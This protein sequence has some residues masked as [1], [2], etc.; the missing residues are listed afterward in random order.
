MIGVENDEQ[1]QPPSDF[2]L[3]NTF[4][5]QWEK[6]INE[7]VKEE[8]VTIEQARIIIAESISHY[9]DTD[10]GEKTLLVVASGTGTGKTTTS[11]ASLNR[12]GRRAIF[13]MP[14]KRH[15]TIL[16]ENYNFIP[17]YWHQWIGLSDGSLVDPE[18]TMCREFLTA[19]PILSARL[20]LAAA[21]AICPI[22]RGDCEYHLQKKSRKLFIAT[23]HNYL[24]SPFGLDGEEPKL[25]FVDEDPTSVFLD[26]IYV[27]ARDFVFIGDPRVVAFMKELMTCCH[28]GKHLSGRDLMDR[29]R[30]YADGWVEAVTEGHLPRTKAPSN[31]TEACSLKRDAWEEFNDVFMRELDAYDA[32]PERYADR[33]VCGETREKVPSMVIKYRSYISPQIENCKFIILDGTADLNHYRNLFPD[34]KIIFVK[35]NVKQKGKLFQIV[36]NQLGITELTDKP[37]ELNLSI[38]K[39]LRTVDAIK[40]AYKYQKIGVVTYKHLVG[41]FEGIAGIDM[42][43]YYG[44]DAT[45][46]NKLEPC[47]ALFVVGTYQPPSH[48]IMDS[49]LCI[50]QLDMRHLTTTT[51]NGKFLP[52]F[53]R[54]FMPYNVFNENGEQAHRFVGGFWDEPL[55][56][57]YVWATIRP[58]IQAIGRA[59]LNLH[60]DHHVWVLSS[61]PTSLPLDG[62][63][64]HAPIYPEGIERDRWAKILKEL[65]QIKQFEF[66]TCDMLA[67]WAG[68]SRKYASAEKWVEK[69]AKHLDAKTATAPVS[70]RRQ[71]CFLYE[72]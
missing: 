18:S 41:I 8:F 9:L 54:R 6:P 69:V 4:K 5:L 21:C 14:N 60:D 71:K 27:P 36:G 66:I 23:S 72:P 49:H 39:T 28:T 47:D 31:R 43:L 64:N 68:V 30:P 67:D 61:L 22:F 63:Y 42:V 62:I 55:L 38:E 37:G 13:C 46:S 16:A 57:A 70:D 11:L 34:R 7:R 65:G 3:K 56:T 12:Y 24:T 17:H 25:I 50:N 10:Y 29:L 53:S 1:N 20:P 58:A 52:L 45:G 48:V 44:G 33:I 2:L 26:E 32:S 35:P 59:R 19:K 15:F 51:K 40:I